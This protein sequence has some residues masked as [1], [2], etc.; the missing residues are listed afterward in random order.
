M[1]IRPYY[2]GPF[3]SRVDKGLLF[4]YMAS[5]ATTTLSDYLVFTI[6][7]SY[8]NTGLLAATVSAYIVGLI[9]SFM[10]NRFWVFRHGADRQSASTSLWRYATFLAVNLVITYLILWGLEQFGVTPY[11]GKLVVGA[12][13]FF[14]IYLGD[15]F[16]VFR[17]E[18]T[19]PIQ[20]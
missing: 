13:M 18:K 2:Q 5:G 16:F 4:K 11:L 10:L 17:G 12:F 6:A 20:L 14:W 3:L 15:T 7:F 9:V 1:V 8:L 19:G